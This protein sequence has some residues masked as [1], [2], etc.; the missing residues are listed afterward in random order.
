M[1]TDVGPYSGLVLHK[2]VTNGSLS[3]MSSVDWIMR[4]RVHSYSYVL[5]QTTQGSVRLHF[6]WTRDFIQAR[7]LYYILSSSAAWRLAA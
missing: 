7:R 5:P 4:A 3:S 6:N 1:D 2:V